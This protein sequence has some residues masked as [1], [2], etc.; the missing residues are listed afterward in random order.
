MASRRRIWTWFLI[1]LLL[2]VLAGPAWAQAPKK[3]PAAAGGKAAEADKSAASDEAPKRGAEKGAKM[4]LPKVTLSDP[5]VEAILDSKPTTPVA[6][7][8]AGKAL[9]D[10]QRPDLA[11]AHFQ[12]VLAAALDAKG[13]AALV[14]EIG[15]EVFVEIGAR[16]EL[17]PEGRQLADAALAAKAQQL[18]DPQRLSALIQKLQGASPEVRSQ[19]IAGL[20]E[21]GVAAVGPLVA[22]LADPKR[23]AEHANMR[24]AL[25]ALGSDVDGPMTAMLDASDPRLAAEALR[26]LGSSKASMPSFF[27]LAP[28][29]QKEGNAEV[30]AAAQAAAKRVWGSIPTRQEAARM[31]ADLSKRYTQE[32]EPMPETTLGQVVIW[33][34]DDAKKAPVAKGYSPGLATRWFAARFARDAHAILPESKEML[35]LYLASM[36]DE[37][38]HENGLD[39][40]LG[41]DKGSPA[42]KASAFPP[43]VVED[44][45]VYAMANGQSGAATAAARILGRMPAAPALLYRKAEPCPLVLALRHPDRRL[46]LAAAEA[47][48]RMQPATPYAGASYLP[49]ALAFMASSAGARRAVVGSPRIEDC[50]RLGG[51]LAKPGLRAD[52]ATTGRQIL[53]KAVRSADYEL[54]LVEATISD[55]TVDFLL[56]ALRRD[57]RMALLPVGVLARAGDLERASH[58]ARNDPRAEVFSRPQSE[59]SARWQVEQLLAR[60]A[61]DALSATERLRHAALA[62]DWLAQLSGAGSPRFYN[63]ARAKDSVIAAL[64]VP[65]LAVKATVVLG[66]LGVPDAQRALVDLASLTT[67]PLALRRAALEGFRSSVQRWGILLTTA[68]IR[69]QYD[70]YNKS[71]KESGT[72]R[73]LLGMILDCIELPAKAHGQV[74]RA[75]RP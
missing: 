14:D 28:C 32:R 33:S 16:R 53:R 56:Q 24:A 69:L 26:V 66:N 37:A 34:W 1:G 38:A 57:G 55:P 68:Q 2:T 25:V 40:P 11:R 74:T 44:V 54:I 64:E 4:E 12:K 29:W 30:R 36:L 20:Q 23:A 13:L 73:A 22:V 45:L 46:R 58:M 65:E 31:L 18:Q 10:L 70:R 75:A 15:S 39:R 9:S 19:A 7:I 43:E 71:V 21:A 52:S 72:T 61:G 8:R 42:D 60:S 59:Q 6:L 5:A 62:L 47:L 48:V 67:A 50:M 27:L 51:F 35:A 41:M 63:V 3:K 49:E 17:A